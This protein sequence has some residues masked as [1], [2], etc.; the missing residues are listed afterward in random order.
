MCIRDSIITKSEPAVKFR[1]VITYKPL[2][3]Y[4]DR[5]KAL[6]GAA[7]ALY[8]KGLPRRDHG[9]ERQHLQPRRQAGDGRLH[10][11][12]PVQPPREY[13]HLPY[14]LCSYT[15]NCQRKFSRPQEWLHPDGR[16]LRRLRSRYKRPLS[17]KPWF[18]QMC[19][20]DRIKIA[21]QQSEIWWGSSSPAKIWQRDYKLISDFVQHGQQPDRCDFKR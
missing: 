8:R 13:V 12:V 18:R 20:R 19:I 6:H 5:R 1:F 11:V 15:L 9:H 4:A 7:G 16:P 3:Y 10:F 17:M 2:D 14:L 21:Y